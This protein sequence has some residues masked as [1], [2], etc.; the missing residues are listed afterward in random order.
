MCLCQLGCLPEAHWLLAFPQIQQTPR[1]GLY[2]SFCWMREWRYQEA[3]EELTRWVQSATLPRYWKRVGQANLASALVYNGDFLAARALLS[4]LLH[5]LHLH[6]NQFLLGF[7]LEVAA[8]ER[9]LASEPKQAAVFLR[10]AAQRWSS[11]VGYDRLFLKKWEILAEVADNP[12]SE[13]ALAALDSFLE[14]CRLSG[15][16]E[17][18]R[19]CLRY[20]ALWTKDS[21]LATQLYFGTPRAAFRQKIRQ[22]FGVLPLPPQVSFTLGTGSPSASCDLLVAP[23]REATVAE[24]NALSLFAI[25]ASDQFSPQRPEQLFARLY[26][27]ER[28]VPGRT[29]KR[30]TQNI[31]RMNSWLLQ[32]K[33]PLFAEES[34]QGYAL[35]SRQTTVLHVPLPD[36]MSHRWQPFLQKL[37]HHFA[38]EDFATADVCRVT[39]E[40]RRTVIRRLQ[41]LVALGCLEQKG[42]G[43]K[44]RYCVGYSPE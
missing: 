1:A 32:R 8:A 37:R 34:P 17:T 18:V 35:R 19:D 21:A 38:D 9:V 26:P 2:R 6:Q 7:V 43:A 30:L 25:L 31:R 11:V 29:R 41:S 15:Q 44:V 3:A 13:E 4:S 33:I 16:T 5:D 14:E 36:D 10:E 40:N 20:R 42:T 28:F 24:R 12:S 23:P 22:E 39:D 27:D